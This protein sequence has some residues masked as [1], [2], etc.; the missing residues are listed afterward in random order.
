MS[1]KIG[2]FLVHIGAMSEDRVQEVLAAQKG[3]DD[4]LFG[5]IAVSKGLLADSALKRFTDFL[6]KHEDFKTDSAS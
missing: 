3:G 1:M 4:R 2:E 6:E 5:E